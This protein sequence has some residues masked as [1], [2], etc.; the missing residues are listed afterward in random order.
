MRSGVVDRVLLSP[1][2]IN[3]NYGQNLLSANDFASGWS[4]SEVTL[5]PGFAIGPPAHQRNAMKMVEST[6]NTDH[7]FSQ[8][9]TKGASAIAYEF[10][11]AARRLPGS[12][13]RHFTNFIFNGSFSSGTQCNVDLDT[14]QMFTSGTFG[15]FTAVSNDV[16]YVGLGW[17]FLRMRFTTDAVANLLLIPGMNVAGFPSPY[18]GDGFSGLLL[19][20]GILRAT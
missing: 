1:S 19:I 10:I 7:N 17:W 16:R 5:T 20:G 13:I 4:P 3:L 11:A 6:N 2:P 15:A 9:Y 14:G 12:G 8:T 18:V